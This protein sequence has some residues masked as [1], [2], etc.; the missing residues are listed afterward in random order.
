M[1]AYNYMYKELLQKM[2]P[3]GTMS[4]Q[5]LYL[6]SNEPSGQITL[7]ACIAY[8]LFLKHHPIKNAFP[9][10]VD[11]SFFIRFSSLFRIVNF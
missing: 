3:S 10:L 11:G 8:Q 2:L 7:N 1:H 9:V 6:F 5:V 4:S